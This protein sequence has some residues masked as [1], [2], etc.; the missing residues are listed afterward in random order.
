MFPCALPG[1]DAASSLNFL[2]DGLRDALDPQETAE[3]WR[4]ACPRNAAVLRGRRNLETYLRARR[5]G[6]VKAVDGVSFDARRRARRWA[7][8]ASPARGK[9]SHL[10]CRSCGLLADTAGAHRGGD[11]VLDGPRPARPADR[12]SCARSA[13][14][15]ISMIFQDPMTSLNPYADASASRSTEALVAAPGHRASAE[16]TATRRR[17]AGPGAASPTPSGASTRIRTS[18]PAACAS[19]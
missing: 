3:A 5:T 14:T 18:S 8:S 10:R 1:D 9:S 15:R 12:A 17:D 11:I 2:G 16:A 7:S 6:V 13:A 4:R 19:G